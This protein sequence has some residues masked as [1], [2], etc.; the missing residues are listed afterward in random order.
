M[1]PPK[2]VADLAGR[3]GIELNE[4][5]FC[6]TDVFSPLETSVP[7]IFVCGAFSS[8]KDIPDTVA[9][10]SG[11]AA[12]AASVISEE[13]GKLVTEKVY[14]PER[15]VSGEDP[16]VGVFIC[17]CGINIGGVIDVPAVVEYAETL[18]NVAYAEHNLFTC[19]VDTQDRIKEIARR[20]NWK[21]SS[22]NNRF[23]LVKGVFKAVL[24]YLQNHAEIEEVKNVRDY[25]NRFEG[26]KKSKFEPQPMSRKDYSKSAPKKCH[27]SSNRS[28]S[29]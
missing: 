16:R 11:A 3:L 22:I 26:V 1:T 18:P 8:P 27:T 2:G 28:K 5:N 12:K 14:P 4:Y 9:Q 29:C 25:L 13:R 6:S 7:G 17:H 15:D 23:S 20:R 21:G 24:R 19:S 10:A